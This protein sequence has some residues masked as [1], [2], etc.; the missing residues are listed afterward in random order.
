MR[1]RSPR[2][3]DRRWYRFRLSVRAM[4]TLIVVLGCSFG[5][6]VHRARVQRDAVNTLLRER[7]RGTVI[8]YDWEYKDG[9][10][11]PNGKLWEPRWLVEVVHQD[12]R[13][14]AARLERPQ[15]EWIAC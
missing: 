12:I 10:Y 9:K 1:N 6:V 4:V 5:W 14:Q 3:R 8:N 13:E 11:T 2:P 7:G 15:L